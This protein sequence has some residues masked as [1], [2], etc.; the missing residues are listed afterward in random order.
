LVGLYEMAMT[1]VERVLCDD[2]K[3]NRLFFKVQ[4]SYKVIAYQSTL[5]LLVRAKLVAQLKADLL[6]IICTYLDFLEQLEFTQ[7]LRDEKAAD[8]LI[9]IS[10]AKLQKMGHV[11]LVRSSKFSE[12]YSKV[13]RGS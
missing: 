6:I 1:Y 11:M 5:K 12:D 3:L 2:L 9:R 4:R 8:N 13:V 10:I 7:Q